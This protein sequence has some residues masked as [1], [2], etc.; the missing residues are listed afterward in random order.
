MHIV[1]FCNNLAHF[2]AFYWQFLDLFW[3][4]CNH[5]EK[6]LLFFENIHTFLSLFWPFFYHFWPFLLLFS[7]LNLPT[8]S[9]K[10]TQNKPLYF[11]MR[12]FTLKS[13][14]NGLI[15]SFN[16]LCFWIIVLWRI[17]S[18]QGLDETH[19]VKQLSWRTWNH[20][21]L[22]SCFEEISFE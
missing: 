6:L 4:F 7:S 9:A 21:T 15:F 10:L 3:L 5:F 20:M 8:K 2:K 13:R 14:N 17:R 16:I 1:L 11:F 19:R 18:L 12:I 22:G